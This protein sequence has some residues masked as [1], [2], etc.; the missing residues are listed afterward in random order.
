MANNRNNCFT[1]LVKVTARPHFHCR[2]QGEPTETCQDPL[3][4]GSPYFIAYSSTAPICFVYTQ[5]SPD[6]KKHSLLWIFPEIRNP[7]CFI[8][9]F[10]ITPVQT[11]YPNKAPLSLM[12]WEL[13]TSLQACPFRHCCVY[14]INASYL[15]SKWNKLT[16]QINP[17]VR[18]N[19]NREKY[20][21]S[22][23]SLSISCFKRNRWGI[24]R[25]FQNHSHAEP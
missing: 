8:T 5:F 14:S 15:T 25:K 9:R 1:V 10:L 12:L 21:I 19:G 23:P 13:D 24:V 11:F 7:E 2:L 16:E 18:K 22:F 17:K 4:V 20:L 3:P 6:S